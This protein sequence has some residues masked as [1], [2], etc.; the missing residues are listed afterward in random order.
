MRLARSLRVLAG[1]LGVA[2]VVVLLAQSVSA[3]SVSDQVEAGVA[4]DRADRVGLLARFSDR[5]TV[6]PAQVVE[7]LSAL[8]AHR[9]ERR[10]AGDA[11]AVVATLAPDASASLIETE[12][13]SVEQ[14]AALGVVGW[15][16]ELSTPVADLSPPDTPADQLVLSVNRHWRIEGID[17]WERASSVVYTFVRTDS[18]WRVRADDA[19]DRI[20]W[21]SD[22]Q[23][24]EITDVDVVRRDRVLVVGDAGTNRLE[25]VADVTAEAL[26]RFD[27]RWDPAWDRAWAGSVM[28]LVPDGLSRLEE[29]LRPTG[30]ASRF[31]AFTTLDIDRGDG[32]QVVSPRIVTQESNL[33]RRSVERQIEV[34]VHE[35][36]HV[37]SV[38][39]SGPATPLWLHEGFADWVT[40]GRPTAEGDLSFPHLHV[41]RTGDVSA[42][43]A[44]YAQAA[45]TMAVLAGDLGDAAVW[46]LFTTTGAFRS[47]AGSADHLVSSVIDELATTSE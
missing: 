44:A 9:S 45:N 18:G 43:S 13:R 25:S 21:A 1:L 23:L 19:L 27:E 3:Q 24:W 4:A 11:D 28:V 35:L 32:W 30:D 5:P 12:R 46:D 15:R 20:G 26:A 42:I 14:A 33:S 10:A 38:H 34:M 16:E 31:V 22:R 2:L 6:A 47:S 7:E 39:E 29:L 37:A 8:L 40:L 17:T 36:V 41:F